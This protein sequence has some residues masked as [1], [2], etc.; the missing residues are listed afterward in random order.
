MDPVQMRGVERLSGLGK[1]KQVSSFVQHALITAEHLEISGAAV[2][3]SKGPSGIVDVGALPGT[4]RDVSRRVHFRNKGRNVCEIRLALN[5][6][7][8]CAA[9]RWI[10]PKV[11]EVLADSFERRR[12]GRSHLG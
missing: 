2:V 6:F 5:E 1:K 12:A 9:S 11:S 10:R 7:H 4:V 3:N 8:D